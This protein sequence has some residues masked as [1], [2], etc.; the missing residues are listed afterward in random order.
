MTLLLEV[1]ERPLD[2]GYAAAAARR[3][4]AGLPPSTG[5]RSPTL[6]G[7][8]VLVGLLLAVA[9][10]TLR[11]PDTVAKQ[12]KDQLIAQIEARRATAERQQARIASLRQEVAATQERSLRLAGGAALTEELARL[13][14]VAGAV[15]VTGPGVRLT[16]DD[17]PDRSGPD[18]PA[19]PDDPEAAEGKVIS[20]DLQLIVNGLWQAGAE[21]VAINDHRLTARAAIR[22]AGEAILVD[23]RPLTRPYVVEAVGDPATLSVRFA[24]TEG[25]SYLQSLR[26]NFGIR[27]DL[28]EVASLTLPGQPSAVL[29]DARPVQ[30]RGAAT[31]STTSSPS[32]PSTG[33]AATNPSTGA[34]P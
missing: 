12:A 2:P 9:A 7:F 24:D 26:S 4:A 29:G 11:V 22:F 19:E 5:T 33:D 20:A 27:G 3:Q 21:A 15:P 32:S 14:Q 34:T 25:G 23:Y 17:A 31:T 1:M 30:P 13:E 10:L 16:I 6:V 28:E 8:A 18:D